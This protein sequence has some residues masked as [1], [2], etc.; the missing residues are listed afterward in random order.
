M[1]LQ[2]LWEWWWQQANATLMWQVRHWCN[3]QRPM[4]MNIGKKVS[5]ASNWWGEATKTRQQWQVIWKHETNLKKALCVIVMVKN[6]GYTSEPSF[7]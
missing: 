6:H 1:E 4:P 3:E 7:W 2:L 5:N